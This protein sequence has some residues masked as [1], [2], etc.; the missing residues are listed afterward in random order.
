MMSDE[1]PTIFVSVAAYRDPACSRTVQQAFAKADHPDKIYV[2][3]CQQNNESDEDCYY[4]AIETAP[5]RDNIKVMRLSAADAKGP[6]FA[7]FLV[8]TLYEGQDFFFQI[9]S[10]TL[11]SPSWDTKLLEEYHKALALGNDKVVLSHYPKDWDSYKEDP[12][13]EEEQLVPHMCKAFFQEGTGMLSFE[14]ASVQHSTG[15]PQRHAYIAAGMFFAPAQ[16]LTDVPFDGELS[17]LFVG[18]EILL[19]ARAFC[20]GYNV[21]SPSVNIVY[22]FYT[23]EKD[24]KIWTDLTYT[25]AEAVTKV[26]R[27]LGMTDEQIDPNYNIER[28]GLK[29][30]R[31]LEDFWKYIGADFENQLVHVNFCED[32]Q[33][34]SREQ[35]PWYT[36]MM[37]WL[38]GQ[39]V[40]IFFL[41]LVIVLALVVLVQRLT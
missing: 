38:S 7:R 33:Q 6:T 4:K 32:H 26:K 18:E 41:L 27:L 9:D 8:T 35:R 17:Y 19:S 37:R 24:P 13:P 3:I 12:T 21:L 11:F 25:D 30:E 34:Q 39:K 23:R 1:F 22:H 31:H 29:T 10:H 14:G 28:F 15:V 20:A 36:K 2:G 40:L 16:F 5:Y